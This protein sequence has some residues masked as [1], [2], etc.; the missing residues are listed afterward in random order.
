MTTEHPAP[1]PPIAASHPVTTTT[2]GHERVDEY[3]WLREKENPEVIAHLEAENAFTAQVMASTSGLQQKIFEEIKNRVLETDLSIPTVKS[4]WAYYQR[5]EEGKQYPI[6]CR[7]PARPE[8]TELAPWPPLPTKPPADEVI[9]L[10]ENLLAEGHDFFAL[11]TFDITR[12]QQ[13]IAYAFDTDGNEVYEL[14][15]RDLASSTDLADVISETSPGVSWSADGTALFYLTLDDAMRPYK[16]WRHIV[17]TEQSADICIFEEPDERFFVGIGLSTTEEFLVIMINSQVTTEVRLLRADNPLGDF[18]IV[19]PRKQNI[20]YAVEHHRA[21]DGSERLFILTNDEAENFRLLVTD[22]AVDAAGNLAGGEWAPA[23]AEWGPDVLNAEG[24]PVERRPKLDSLEVFRSHIVLHERADGLERIRVIKL[25]DSGELGESHVIEQ[26]EPVH[27]VWPTGNAR[28]DTDILRFGYT[29]MTTPSS[30]E[31]YDMNTGTRVL[32]KRQPVLG[33]FD[34]THYVAERVWATA[35][36]GERIPI[37]LVRH[38]ATPT[39]GSA[40]GVLYGY[41]SYE[42]SIDPGF[43]IARL[44]LLDRGFVFAIA[45]IRGGGEMGRSW[46]LDGKY[47]K[48]KNTFNDFLACGDALIDQRFVSADRL[49]A[50]GGSAGGL[51]MGAVVNARPDLFSGIVAEVPFVDVVNTMLDETL[52][53]T[54][55][56]WEEWGNPNDPEYYE[57]MRSYAPYENVSAQTYPEMLVTAGLNDPRV[58]YWEPAKFVQRL[59]NKTTGTQRILLKTEMGAGHGGPSGRYDVWRDEAFVLSFILRCAGLAPQ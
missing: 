58:S 35:T 20:E 44:S 7:R 37:S 34:P 54:A 42:I 49:I 47:L 26:S 10:D 18:E 3:G 24:R 22:V 16:V 15:I 41:G 1:R 56:E 19:A 4:T 55:I 57:Y 46:Y 32:R 31:D 38:R 8:D 51:L 28:F 43:S 12:D 5:T 59:R 45:H 27:S 30:V 2:H 25:T 17:G 40:P 53:L 11:G 50:R 21:V 48:K 52:P 9:L 14:H 39:D 29:S 33:D 36:D 6:H 23:A 13:R